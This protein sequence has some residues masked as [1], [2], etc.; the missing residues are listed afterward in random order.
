MLRLGAA[1]PWPVRLDV[2]YSSAR[3]SYHNV[4]SSVYF[5]YSLVLLIFFNVS[6]ITARCLLVLSSPP[7]HPCTQVNGPTPSSADFSWNANV[8][9]IAMTGAVTHTTS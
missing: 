7:R 9:E 6:I 3:E 4:C 1:V 2:L 8:V 5:P